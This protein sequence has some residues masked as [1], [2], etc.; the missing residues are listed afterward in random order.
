MKKSL[1]LILLVAFFLQGKS[2]YYYRDI[3]NSQQLQKDIVQLKERKIRE[4]SIKSFDSD[5]TPSEGFFC[6]KKISKDFTRTE[7][8]TRSDI[9]SASLLTSTFDDQG[10]ILQ[11]NDSS[12]ISVS[13]TRYQYNDQ[14]KVSHILSTVISSDDDF[15]SEMKEEHVYFYDEKGYPIEMKRVKNGKDTSLILFRT[16][17]QGN[18]TIEKN[19]K[20]GSKYYYY[21][22]NRHLL[23]DVVLANEYKN[24]LTPQYSFE[25]NSNGQITQMSTSAEGGGTYNVWKYKYDDGLRTAEKCYAKGKQLLG[26]VEYDYNP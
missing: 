6:E 11:I 7:L 21:Y 10:R 24:N 4:V 19:T 18:V 16:D 17:E 25:Y 2:Q 9:S 8:F 1:I 14:G 26:S 5:G 12:K 22:N 20:T 3:L 15:H 23:S 13:Y